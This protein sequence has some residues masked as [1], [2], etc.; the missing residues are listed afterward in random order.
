MQLSSDSNVADATHRMCDLATALSTEGPVSA[1]ELDVAKNPL[2]AALQGKS[3]LVIV[4]DVWDQ[5]WAD[6]F[7]ADMGEGSGCRLFL[8][9]RQVDIAAQLGEDQCV[10][11]SSFGEE[12]AEQK[13]LK[14]KKWSGKTGPRVYRSMSVCSGVALPLAIMGSLVRNV[15]WIAAVSDFNSGRK[16]FLVKRPDATDVIGDSPKSMRMCLEA[17]IKA[18]T[19]DGLAPWAGRCEELCVVPPKEKLP[20]KAL[21]LLWGEDESS[22]VEV[23]PFLRDRSLVTLEGRQN[24][25]PFV[26]P[27]TTS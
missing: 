18:M 27:C 12:H 6:E 22:A 25:T 20:Q 21:A 17:S 16:A 14:Y 4:D 19:R 10:E 13:P 1:R 26:T 11:V 2:K 24:R 5:R 7:I 15:G 8:S 9:T 23:A 3:C